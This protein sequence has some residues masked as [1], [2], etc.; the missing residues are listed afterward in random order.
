M[1]GLYR[2]RHSQRG[3]LA[4]QVDAAVQDDQE[5]RAV[6]GSVVEIVYLSEEAA[7]I[8]VYDFKCGRCSH[9]HEEYVKPD[10]LAIQCPACRG[11]A[12]RQICAPAMVKGNFADG[13]GFRKCR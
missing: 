2:A 9:R 13:P 3:R 12:T 7:M 5:A 4:G 6:A 8:K 1:R 11:R 10:V